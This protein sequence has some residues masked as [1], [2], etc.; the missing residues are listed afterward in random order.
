MNKEEIRKEKIRNKWINK[1]R[2]VV[3]AWR[4]V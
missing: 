4:H 2:S 3:C 1:R